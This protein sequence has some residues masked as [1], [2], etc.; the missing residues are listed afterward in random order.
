MPKMIATM[1]QRYDG[2]TISK[3][4]IF[5]VKDGDVRLLKALGRV[6]KLKVAAM[7]AENTSA[8]IPNPVRSDDVSHE[9]THA[10]QSRI[11]PQPVPIEPSPSPLVETETVD[12]VTE[13]VESIPESN[14]NIDLDELAASDNESETEMSKTESFVEHTEYGRMLR[15]KAMSLGIRVDGRWSDARVQREI[16]EYNKRT[17]QHMDIRAE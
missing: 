4:D 17:Y 2:H 1:R 14:L 16:D 11:E 8:L 7:S 13:E 12:M 5:N 15:D 3:N 9:H 6:A 10:S